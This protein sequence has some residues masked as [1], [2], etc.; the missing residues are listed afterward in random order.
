MPQ[1][2]EQKTKAFTTALFFYLVAGI[3]QAEDK[4]SAQ[5][6]MTAPSLV[7][8][9]FYPVAKAKHPVPQFKVAPGWPSLPADWLIGQVPGLAVDAQDNVWLLHRPNSLNKLDLGLTGKIGLC[10]KAAPHVLQFSPQGRLLNAWGGPE[11]APSL[12][13]V[14]Q[15]PQNVHGLYVDDDNTV[16]L[17]GNG[18]GDHVVLNF[19]AQG[20]FIKQFGQRGETDGNNSEAYLG[21]PADVF[22][23]SSENRVFIADGYINK[24]IASYH[25]TDNH[26]D[27]V[28]GAYGNSPRGGTRSG[29]FDVSQATANADS[30]SV[31][32][33]N[34]GDIVHCVTQSSDGR[35]YVCDRRNNRIQIFS[36]NDDGKVTFV[37]DLV[38]AGE[39]GG[40]GTASDIA[41]S[42]DNRYMYVADMMNGRIWIL[43]HQTYEVLGSFGRPGR[44]AG[45]FTWLHSVVA[46]SQGNLYTSEVSTGRRVQKFVLTGFNE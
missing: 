15:W 20:E 31:E 40:L 4:G 22:H 30:T 45:Q 14:N 46:D 25:T 36:L 21:N 27:Q 28:W 42:P 33:E 1:G 38:I 9:E 10:C 32:A 16:W 29:S 3:C 6:A 18:D 2:L 7:D 43:W 35:I 19:N 12:A 26:F 5:A 39:T 24:R 41:F 8:V 11:I 37:K 13:G 23:N 34:F 44:Y 17:G